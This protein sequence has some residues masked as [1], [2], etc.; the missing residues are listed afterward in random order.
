[1]SHQPPA[2]NPTNPATGPSRHHRVP[3]FDM[4]AASRARSGRSRLAVSSFYSE[5][6]MRSSLRMLVIVAGAA[7]LIATLRVDQIVSVSPDG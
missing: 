1:R 2:N 5:A 3:E 4:H 7:A 6:A